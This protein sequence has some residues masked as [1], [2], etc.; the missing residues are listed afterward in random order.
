MENVLKES[1][2]CFSADGGKTPPLQHSFPQR[3]EQ[4]YLQEMEH[5][6]SV[7]RDPSIPLA[8]TKKEVI[9]SSRVADACERSLKEGLVTL[10]KI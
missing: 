5:F 6:I 3:Y 8:V 9:L 1:T 7:V 4:A 10:D 2:H